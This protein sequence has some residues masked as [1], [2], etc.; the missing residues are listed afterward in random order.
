M[1][2]R[3][4]SRISRVLFPDFDG[5]LHPGK[6]PGMPG[7]SKLYQQTGPVVWLSQ[8]PRALQPP[9]DVQVVVHSTWRETYSLDELPEMLAELGERRLRVKP[10]G[11]RFASILTWLRRRQL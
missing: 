3:D 6:G 2:Q 5:V 10:P 11:G 7:P 1:S 8:L 9:L 4:L